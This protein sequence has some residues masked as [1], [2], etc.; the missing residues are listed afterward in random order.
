MKRFVITALP[1]LFFT[2]SS[3]SPLGLA[4]TSSVGPSLSLSTLWEMS[5]GPDY[6]STTDPTERDQ[7][8]FV[9]KFYLPIPIGPDSSVQPLYRLYGG[10]DHMDSPFTNEGGYSL[11][12]QIGYVFTDRSRPG[13]SSITRLYD[14]QAQTYNAG[15]HAIGVEESPIPHAEMLPSYVPDST[16]GV[17]YPRYPGT[18]QVMGWLSASGVTAKSNLAVGCSLWEWWWNGVE[19]INDFDYGRQIQS[20]L[21]VG[22]LALG[23]AGD[24]Y[25]PGSKPPVT[26]PDLKH[27]SPC[28]SYSVSGNTQ[29]TSAVPL[30]FAS[31][32]VNSPVIYPQVQIGK[33]LTLDWIGPDGLDR[34]WNVGQ[35]KTTISVPSTLV[36]VVEAPSGY[37]NAQFINNYGTYSFTAHA[38]VAIPN[39]DVIACS[40][41]YI[42]PPNDPNCVPDQNGI[43][44]GYNVALPVGPQGL[45]FV[46]NANHAMGIY[47][48]A[49]N[50]QFTL[51][52]SPDG[53]SPGQYGSSFVKWG[54]HFNGGVTTPNW[55]FKT[56]IVTDTLANVEA[57]M[58]TLYSWKSSVNSQQ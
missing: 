7:H 45:I 44:N 11:E 5:L 31:G 51:V 37:L 4:Q 42:P 28:S 10:S 39:A 17:G 58:D 9:A 48:N 47:I 54:V 21:Y 22:T 56:W 13:T 35:Y 16:L 34:K 26:N 40:P 36:A 23:E 1:I 43:A 57:A 38:L 19:Y 24:Q 25:G 20:S 3:W 30:D 52:Q 49:Q 55:A 14:N 50:A 12:G 27:P 53:S 18:D 8:P 46:D 29:T 15:D 41:N 33:E 32:T 2:L 6:T